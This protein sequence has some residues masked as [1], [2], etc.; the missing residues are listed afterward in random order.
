MAQQL[1]KIGEEY[2]EVAE[3]VAKGD[4]ESAA[5]EAL[6]VIQTCCTMLDMIVYFDDEVDLSKLV[7]E[8]NHK[9]FR[10]GYLK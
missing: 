7:N 6:D 8:H 3:A 4:L 9:L 5:R 2:G 1:A 10:K